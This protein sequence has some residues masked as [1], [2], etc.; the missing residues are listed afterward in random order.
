MNRK[1]IQ[2]FIHNAFFQAH[3]LGTNPTFWTITKTHILR[4]WRTKSLEQ[5]KGD[6]KAYTERE[7]KIIRQVRLS[8]TLTQADGKVAIETLTSIL[9]GR[10][11]GRTLEVTRPKRDRKV[12]K[13]DRQF[14][15][16][17]IFEGM[18][19]VFNSI[20]QKN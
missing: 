2:L 6:R 17:L 8:K 11:T 12:N 4:H 14:S 13:H 18:V 15:L 10:S 1:K 5:E 16:L 9:R 19:F 20:T 3:W 7:K